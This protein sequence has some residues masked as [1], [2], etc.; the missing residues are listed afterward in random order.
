MS[1]W[2][3]LFPPPPASP[4]E[5]LRAWRGEL[6]GVACRLHLR[7]E[8]DGTGLLL[9]NASA[10]VRL[11]PTGVLMADG[12]LQD[13]DDDAIV[14]RVRKSFAAPK[15][16]VS[17]DL[18][19]LRELLRRLATAPGGAWPISD[20]RGGSGDGSLSA[21]LEAWVEV[22]AEEIVIPA[23]DRLFASG[24]PHVTLLP[25]EDDDLLVRSVERAEDLGMICGVRVCGGSITPETLGRLVTAGLD[26]LQV[27]VL[28]QEPEAHDALLG[29]GDHV[30]ALALLETCEALDL[31]G[32]AEVPILDANAHALHELAGDLAARG[33]GVLMAWPV[34]GGL[35][36]AALPQVL[37]DIEELA[38]SGIVHVLRA[39]PQPPDAPVP[40]RLRAGPAIASDVSMRV[41]ADGEE[42]R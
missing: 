16:R 1:L 17:A 6:G 42:A 21:P 3:R 18:A 35:S 30:A 13:L 36:D 12:L 26:C 2:S 33:C 10:A 15:A 39:P 11:A 14:S 8:P 19:E 32:V 23:L 24:V 7:V 29:D 37:E 20:L 25:G 41:S 5:G 40:E 22:G 38:E 28:A 4:A 9:I 34:P 27:P 31:C